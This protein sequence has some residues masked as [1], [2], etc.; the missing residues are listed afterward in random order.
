MLVILT[1]INIL[2]SNLMV[3]EIFE[4]SN[5]HTVLVLS[6][7][8]FATL[9]LIKFNFNPKFKKLEFEFK[10]ISSLA[11]IIGTVLL[12]TSFYVDGIY[13]EIFVI[14][15]ALFFLSMHTLKLIKSH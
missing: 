8:T 1:F 3:I 12:I 7:I 2:N 13:S 4:N 5:N 9:S 10:G 14:F 15:G 11:F 6:G